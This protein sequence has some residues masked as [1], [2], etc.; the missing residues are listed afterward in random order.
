MAELKGWP[1][2]DANIILM[3]EILLVFGIFLMN[4]AESAWLIT[5]NESGYH[6]VLSSVFAGL[7]TSLSPNTLHILSQLGWW[8]HLIGIFGFI[9]YLPYS[10]HL[11]ILLAFPNAYLSNPNAKGH[12]AYMPEI[13]HEIK[14]MMGEPVEARTP[15]RFQNLERKMY[16]IYRRK[17]CWT[18]MLAQNVVDVPLPVL[19]IKLGKNFLLAKS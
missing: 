17:I 2:K 16:L 14:S 3:G 7:F 15:M 6:F 1:M 12:I 19:P 10:K 4:S 9:L 11:H 8:M 13:L 18:H 5:S